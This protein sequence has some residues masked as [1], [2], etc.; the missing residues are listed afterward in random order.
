MSHHE[1]IANGVQIMSDFQFVDF[2][3]HQQDLAARVD[4]HGRIVK[5]LA[6][7]LDEP[8]DDE[9]AV[10]HRSL[11]EPLRMWPGNRLCELPRARIG[12]AQVHTF[13]QDNETTALSGRIANERFGPV[14]IGNRLSPRDEHLGHADS[15]FHD[16]PRT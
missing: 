2:A 12:P 16:Y 10:L 8:G 3:V 6:G 11:R 7:A 14:K 9:Y 5:L 1:T 15:V 13:G 4:Q